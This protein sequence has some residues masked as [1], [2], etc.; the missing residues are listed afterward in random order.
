MYQ[1]QSTNERIQFYNLN[2]FFPKN[3]SRKMGEGRGN[4]LGP[5]NLLVTNR[6]SDQI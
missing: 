6:M 2:N 4:F 3:G 5:D 1:N